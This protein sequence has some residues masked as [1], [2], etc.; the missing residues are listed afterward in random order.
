MHR[1][2]GVHLKVAMPNKMNTQ[3]LASMYLDW[4]SA[5]GHRGWNRRLR[6]VVTVITITCLFIITVIVLSCY[7]RRRLPIAPEL[8]PE[9]LE[10]DGWYRSEFFR[11]RTLSLFKPISQTFSGSSTEELCRSFPNHLT[12][13]KI[14]PVLKIGHTEDRD[15]VDAQLTSVSA[16]IKDLLIFSDLDETIHGRHV[17]DVLQELPAAYYYDNPHLVNYTYLRKLGPPPSDDFVA[18]TVDS[19]TI[20]GW[21]LDKYKFLPMVERAWT[22]RPNR[23]WYFFYESDTYVVWD[24]LFRF[25][26][27]LDH[28]TPL[29]IGSPSPGRRQDPDD[30][31][32]TNYFANG[33]PG[34][35]LSRSAVLKL[36]DRKVG[37]DGDYLQAP[38]THRWLDLMKSDPCGDSIL[39]W[40]LHSVGIRLSGFWPLFNPH[41]LHAIPFSQFYWCQPVLTLHKTKPE[42]MGK[43]WRW[44]QSRRVADVS[45]DNY[46]L[47]Y[48]LELICNA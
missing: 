36:L 26:Q 19:L 2:Y 16:C 20:N 33:G 48:V 1:C 29:Y 28:D 5:G 46:I 27:N 12:Q 40:A 8:R 13:H 37:K 7:D 35:A 3:L 42:D 15:R 10:E 11:W 41:A 17:I 25:L 39:G 44:E 9:P 31:L 43:L 24:N 47:A 18:A 45:E 34:F 30:P 4:C 23:E 21:E 32:T 22:M 38:L 6:R 14:Q